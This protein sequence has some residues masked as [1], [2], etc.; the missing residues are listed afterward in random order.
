M[1]TLTYTDIEDEVTQALG[2]RDDITSARKTR[3]INLAQIRIAR[4][5]RWEELEAIFDKT[6][7]FTSDAEADKYIAFPDTFRD[8]Y[9]VVL[10]DGS[11]SRKLSRRHTRWIDRRIAMP[12]H[13][14]RRRPTTYVLWRNI[15]ELWPVQDAAYKLRA[16]AITWP[17]AFV[18]SAAPNAVSD[19]DR[20]DDMLVAL[21][22]SWAF[23]TVKDDDSANSWWRIYKEM[24]GLA[25]DEE[26]ERPDMDSLPDVGVQDSI[27]AP[28]PWADPFV[29][30]II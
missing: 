20:K 29:R 22:T 11:R 7:P 28:D 23:K 5:W 13:F 6:L 26:Q 8:A 24:L 2:N 16:R 21:S 19:F 30:S 27:V 1:G 14:A 18:G 15:M 17:T 4:A 3:I 25:I 9:S 10:L 12:E